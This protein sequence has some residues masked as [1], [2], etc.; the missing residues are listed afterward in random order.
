VGTV[1][2]VTHTWSISNAAPLVSDAVLASAEDDALADTIAVLIGEQQRRALE[3][4]D[5]SAVIEDAFNRAFS[6]SKALPPYLHDGLLIVPG[7]KRD[8]GMNHDCSFCSI[9]DTWVWEHGDV[10][11]DDIRHAVDGRHPVLRTIT[12]LPAAEGMEIDQVESRTK[13]G[14]HEMRQVT[15]F[16]IRGGELVLVSTRA[17]KTN[18]HGGR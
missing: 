15:S 6:G 8:R 18:G 5:V 16:T 2:Q 9:S 13:S 3:R 14:V 1:V 4:N 11:A 7:L 17:R 12:V 10:V